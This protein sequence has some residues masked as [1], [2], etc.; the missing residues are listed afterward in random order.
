MILVKLGG[1]LIAPKGQRKRA[2]VRLIHQLGRELAR[3]REPLIVIHGAGSFGHTL[4]KKHAI[5]AGLHDKAQLP[6]LA[7]IHFDIRLLNASVLEALG[8]SGLHAVSV[9]PYA[10]AVNR[11]GKLAY[12]DVSPFGRSLDIGLT[13][14]TH[15]DAVT[16]EVRGVSILSGDDIAWWLSR[17]LKPR[18]MIFATDVDGI[19]DKLPDE[20]GATLF[21]ELTPQELLT[22]PLGGA[23]GPDVTG[24]MAGKARAIATIADLGVPVWVVNGAKR[25]RLA[26]VFDGKKPV[27][28]VVQQ[29]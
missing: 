5:H 22:K 7:A 23:R 28:T 12:L 2:D 13:P 24:G 17:E 21:R 27:G 9:S 15:G 1:G 20:A 16:D 19:F 11:D 10:I 8:A 18:L 4:A 29:E 3:A 14:V 25:G 6:P 26:A